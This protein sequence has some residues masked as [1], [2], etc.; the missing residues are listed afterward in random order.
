MVVRGD[1]TLLA[2]QMAVVPGHTE[3]VI[4][5]IGKTIL[6][7][8]FCVFPHS[9]ALSLRRELHSQ[10]LRQWERPEGAAQLCGRCQVSAGESWAVLGITSLVEISPDTVL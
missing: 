1:H 10:C 9:L 2:S 7:F 4:F 3:A 5:S 8:L 6:E